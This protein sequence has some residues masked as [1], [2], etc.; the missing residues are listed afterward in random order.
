MVER[1]AGM[2][3]LALLAVGP[4]PVGVSGEVQGG[5]GRLQYGGC[6]SN[7]YNVKAQSGAASL[8]VRAPIGATATVEGSIVGGTV[9]N[10]RSGVNPAP[11]GTQQQF[12][13]ANARLGWHFAYGG[14]EAG[15]ASFEPSDRVGGV[16]FAP[17]V[18]AWAGAPAVVYGWGVFAAGPAIFPIDARPTIGVGLGHTDGLF[19]VQAGFDQGAMLRASLTAFPYIKPGIDLRYF[20]DSNWHV[21]VRVAFTADLFDRR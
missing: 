10:S 7:D 3:L 18:S 8:A 11:I 19:D 14:A 20:D 4:P 5:V 12:W 16:T 1:V 6:A 13:N 21:A 17:S 15:L 9:T 2:S